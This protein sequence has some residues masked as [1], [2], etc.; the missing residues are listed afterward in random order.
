MQC[1]VA[2]GFLQHHLSS[3]PSTSL[4]PLS[5]SH[6]GTAG[7]PLCTV[8]ITL[9][10]STWSQSILHYS[11]R[12]SEALHFVWHITNLQNVTNLQTYN[13]LWICKRYMSITVFLSEDSRALV[14]QMTA[15]PGSPTSSQIEFSVSNR[16]ACCPTGFNSGA[17][18]FLCI[19]QQCR[20]RQ[21]CLPA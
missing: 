16:R 2:P 5:P 11:V 18:S 6:K 3:Q 19:Y 7:S 9:R 20:Y 21:M 8:E 15:S 14:S 1:F 4:T 10:S 12:K 13:M 17:D